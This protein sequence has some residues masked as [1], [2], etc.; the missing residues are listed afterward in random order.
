MSITSQF[1][2]TLPVWGG[3][4]TFY[5]GCPYH[6][7]FNPPSPCGEGPL[8][9]LDD[10]THQ[11]FQSTLPVWGGTVVEYHPAKADYVFQS[12]LPVW[13]GTTPPL[14][15]NRCASY[16][17]PPSPCG[18]GPLAAESVVDSEDFNPPSPCGEGPPASPSW[19]TWPDFNPPS[20]CG[21]VI[22]LMA[23]SFSSYCLNIS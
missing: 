6:Q 5:G 19:Q 12:T 11:G 14:P 13:G 21:N 7:D 10:V 16:F 8:H 4:R 9:A 20:P 1:Q 22:N 3:T 17:N 2:S 18:E 15:P 23:V